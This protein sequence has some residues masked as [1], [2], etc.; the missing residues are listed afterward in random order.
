MRLKSK[1]GVPLKSLRKV[2]I[3]FALGFLLSIGVQSLVLAQAE[4][5]SK[6]INMLVGYPPGGLSDLTARAVASGAEKVLK[7]P[8]IVVNKPGASASLAMALLANAKPD[9]YT[10]GNIPSTATVIMPFVEKVSYDPLKDFTP[11]INQFNYAAA[12]VVRADAPW[13]NFSE[14][15]QYAKKNPN[16]V[17]Y[18]TYGAYGTTTLAM[19]ALGKKLGLQWDTVPFKSD[20]EAV[21]GLLGGHITAAA[22]ASMYAPQVRAGLLKILVM[23]SQKRSPEFPDAPTFKELGFNIVAEGFV[24]VGGPKGLPPAIVI[25]LENAFT[26]ALKDKGYLELIKKLAL[27]EDYK[28]S[29]E[30]SKFI[31]ESFNL[32]RELIQAVGLDKLKG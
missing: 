7:Q 26:E 6:P 12:L 18:G 32:H 5:P 29:K 13:K 16:T 31:E 9:G 3:V 22:S 30:F 8:V 21:V 20:A 17:K 28:N 10:L 14:F 25:K 23:M 27:V 24:G 1:E 2:A 19:E 15:I 11:I 4:Y